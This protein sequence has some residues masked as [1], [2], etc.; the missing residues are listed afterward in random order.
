MTETNSYWFK[1]GMVYGKEVKNQCNAGKPGWDKS[2]VKLTGQNC[3]Q[4]RTEV[5][6][7]GSPQLMLSKAQKSTELCLWPGKATDDKDCLW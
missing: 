6:I 7:L 1:G 5:Q 3:I 2:H 4:C